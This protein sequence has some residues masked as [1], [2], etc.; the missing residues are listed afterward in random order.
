MAEI[1]PQEFRKKLEFSGPVKESRFVPPESERFFGGQSLRILWVFP[2]VFK[3]PARLESRLL[4]PR[5]SVVKINYAFLRLTRS[6]GLIDS[7]RISPR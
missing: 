2:F 3:N 6:D 5:W 1:S 7:F 4:F